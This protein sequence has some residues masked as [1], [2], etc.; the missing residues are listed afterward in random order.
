MTIS[1]SDA[2]TSITQER[3]VEMLR[4]M[5]DMQRTHN[6]QVHPQW[7]TR[8]YAYYRAIWV[9]CAEML[10]HFGWKWWKQQAV[11]LPQVKLELVDIWHFALSELMR[12]GTL[13]DEMAHEL[14]TLRS[15]Q[16]PDP[17]AFRCA[18]ESL[19]ADTLA[20]Q[21]FSLPPFLRA[22]QTL[23]MD[24][25][26]LFAMYIGKNVLNGFRQDHGYK[27][28]EYRKLWAGREDNEH[29]VELLAE[30]SNVNTDA[31]DFPTHLYRAL[32]ARYQQG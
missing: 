2:N 32:D 3:A 1:Q 24:Y 21:S 16:T 22:M 11:D 18:I 15:E 13:R 4:T 28:G 14:S 17:E 29:L 26:E 7:E 9:E 31:R 10:D 12:A 19:A 6:E 23:P 5:A 25:E 30:L 27:T 8:G 20:T